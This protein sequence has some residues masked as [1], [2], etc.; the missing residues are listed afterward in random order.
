MRTIVKGKNI[1][2]PEDVRQYAERKMRRLERFLD[3][4]TDAV[5][6]LSSEQHRTADDSQIAEV[7][8]IVDGQPLRGHAAG[9]TH[10]ASLDAVIDRI[11]RQ[12]VDAREKPRGKVRVEEARARRIAETEPGNDAI[13]TEAAPGAR[14][15]IVKTKRFAI[16]PMFEE[17]ALERM[18]ELGHHFFIFVNAESEKVSILYK[19][20]AG[21][22]GLIEPM[23]GGAYTPGRNGHRG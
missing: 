14:K 8:L 5:V 20:C 3:D 1:D 23:I 4:R 7:T 11:E 13:A 16:E 19:R 9:P 6:E 12:A 18:E 2:V 10:Q 17:D 15:A 22:Y 21:D